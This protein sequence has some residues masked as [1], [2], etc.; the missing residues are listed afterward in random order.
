MKRIWKYIYIPLFS[1]VLL[2]ISVVCVKK[3]DVLSTAFSTVLSFYV[4][5]E[6]IAVW[7]AEDGNYYVFLPSYADMEQVMLSSPEDKRITLG[8]TVLS[9]SMNCSGFV[10]EEPYALAVN[11]KKVATLWFCQSANVATLYIDTATGGMKHIHNDKNYEENVSVALYTAEGKIHYSDEKSILKGRGN[12]TWKYDKRPYSLILPADGDLLGMGAASNW[13]L[14]ANAHDETNLNNKLM[15]DLAAG[16]GLQWT[17]ESRWVDLYLNGTYHG[18]YL[19]TEKVEVHENRLDIDANSGNFLC[20]IDLNSRWNT[21]RNPFLTE[22]GRT[23]EINWPE[24]LTASSQAAVQSIVNQMEQ[25]ILSGENIQSS[26]QLDLD[27]WICRYLID[28]ISGNID[29][30]LASSYFYIFDGKAYAGPAWD[31]DMALGNSSRSQEPCAFLAMNAQKAD[32]YHSPYYSALYANASFYDRMT[33]IYRTQFRPVIQQLLDREIDDLIV[34]IGKAAQMNSLRWRAMF[35]NLQS[36]EPDTVCTPMGVKDYLTRRIDFLDSA[37]LE[38]TEYCTV[39]LESAPGSAYWNIS[40]PKGGYLETSYVDLENFTWLDS[41]T[42]EIFDFRQPIMNDMI[43]SKQITN[44]FANR[45][46]ITF[47]SIAL[48]L[49][50]LM[51]FGIMDAVQR[52]KERKVSD[53]RKRT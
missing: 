31:Y 44:P 45:D 11:E 46:Y 16:T 13:V 52:K 41:A 6:E 28:E 18:L 19:L 29:A 37:W 38:N 8:D 40:V 30:D 23:V 20:R 21:L 3:A 48:L 14:L 39:Q 25:T 12:A 36:Q 4:G 49:A 32:S 35:D 42:G 33:E 9:G 51:G 26:S 22:G 47:L 2:L 34:Y 1:V 43:L 53:E 15:L 7:D 10:P 50:V 27:S 5:S 17:P 24:T